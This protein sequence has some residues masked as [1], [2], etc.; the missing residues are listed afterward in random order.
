MV[1]INEQGE[2][3]NKLATIT[4][5]KLPCVVGIDETEGLAVLFSKE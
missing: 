4:K 2:I 3:H 1:H 5:E